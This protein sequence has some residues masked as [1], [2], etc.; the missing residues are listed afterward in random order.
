MC[1]IAELGEGV[2]KPGYQ[3]LALLGYFTAENT[4]S[5]LIMILSIERLMSKYKNLKLF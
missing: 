1:L 5:L 4:Y 2:V 3:L